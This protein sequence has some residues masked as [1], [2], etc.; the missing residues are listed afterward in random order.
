MS[1]DQRRKIL[2][3][4]DWYEPGFKAG[5][6]IRSCVNFVRYMREDYL[7]Y[8][9]TTDRDLGSTAPYEGIRTDV[10]SGAA[11][12]NVRI[13]YCSPAKLTWGNIRQQLKDLQPDHIYLNSMFSTPFTIYP[14][15]IV[16][17]HGLK[18]N[19]VL[20]P[21]GMLRASALRFKP[22]KKQVFLKL[23]RWTGLYR[24]L[25]FH[26]SDTTELQ[27]VQLHFGRKAR[28]SMISNFPAAPPETLQP[29]EKLA[30][31]LS[32]IFIGRIHPIKNLDFLL[33]VLRDARSRIRLTIVGS[34]EDKGYWE[35]CGQL[36]R[37]LPGNIVVSYA[38]EIP[39]QDLPALTNA[40]H[41]FALPTMGEN[42]G[43]AIFESLSLGRPVLISDQT[44]WRNLAAAGAGWDLPLDK[45]ELFRQ[46]IEEAAG[47]DQSAYNRWSQST[48]TFVQELIAQST[49][50]KDYL[51]LFS[52]QPGR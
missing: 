34:L 33:K 12:P 5:G 42:F 32:M 28:V 46:A 43:H 41:I 47:F 23:F 8:V 19:I 17:L 10:W 6:P 36:I 44:P 52:R 22:F 24:P 50:Q 18:G 48:F 1:I 35:A 7:L 37:Q 27:D 11:H 26:A 40:H 20:S 31:E 51:T 29:V 25:S 16:Q 14:L 4:A 13:Y 9:F 49:L 38:G 2:V 21:R 45:P 3:F 30:G 15:L 39:N